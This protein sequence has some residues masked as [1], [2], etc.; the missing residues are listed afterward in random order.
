MRYRLAMRL[1]RIDFIGA[2]HHVMN[3]GARHQDV[4][5]DDDVRRLFLEIIKDLPT[6]FGV[7][8]HGYALMPN[9]YHLM[10]ESAS[11]ELPRAMRHLGGEFTRQLNRLYRWDGPIFRGRY[12]NRIVG[13]ETYW[14][15]LL[16]YVHLNPDRAGLTVTDAPAWTSHA[17]YMGEIARPEWL[18]TGELQEIF[19]SQQAY[20]QQYEA[21]RLGQMPIITEFDPK[22]LWAPNSTGT[23]ALPDLDQPLWQVADALAQVCSA[24]GQTLEQLLTTP[25]GR[26]G[27]PAN[28][29]AAW[30]MSRR[31][32]IDHGQICDVLGASHTTISKRISRIEKRLTKDPQ[33]RAW[34]SALGKKRS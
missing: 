14:Q 20:V 33:V 32:G 11:A 2:R 31:G 6:R 1:P 30:W 25:I 7:R 4:F 22:R 8:V 16:I 29:L 34:V 24:T 28:W 12:R 13:T 17:A 27:N 15:H 5:L 21:R 23:V 18:T 10:L 9:H 26:K 3:R 19:G